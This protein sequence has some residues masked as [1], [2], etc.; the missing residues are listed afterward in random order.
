VTRPEGAEMVQRAGY[1]YA[2]NTDTGGM[3]MEEDPYSIFR[4]NIFPNETTSSLSKKTSK[5][6]RRYYKFKRNK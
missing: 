6:Y 2:L 3:L 5:W 4:V 1:E